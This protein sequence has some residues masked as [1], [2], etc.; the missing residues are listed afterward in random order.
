[1]LV[2][3]EMP[4]GRRR[5]WPIYKA[6]ER[7]GL[8]IGIHAGSAY[9]HPITPVGW[10]S[11]HAED[12]AA[13]AQAFQTTLSSLMTEGVFAE[14]PELKVVSAGVWLRLA[15]LPYVAAWKVLAWPAH[16]DPLGRPAPHGNRQ[17]SRAPYHQPP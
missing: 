14:F 15:A 1:M 2:M 10:P 9:R 13:Q 4:L 17:G 11:Y 5:Y 7:H 3:D 8:P 6:A 12:S 16:G